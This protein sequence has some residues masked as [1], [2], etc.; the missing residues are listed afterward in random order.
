MVTKREETHLALKEL[1]VWMVAPGA[2]EGGEAGGGLWLQ[3]EE[4]DACKGEGKLTVATVGAVEERAVVL[5]VF[6]KGRSFWSRW[7]LLLLLLLGASVTG[8]I[9][10]A[11]ERE[12]WCNHRV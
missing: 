1:T 5:A 2:T 8:E 7:L 4:E 12:R 6:G 3:L 9:N 11:E 10:F